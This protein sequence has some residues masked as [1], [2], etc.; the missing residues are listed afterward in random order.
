MTLAVRH[1]DLSLVC[2]GTPSLA[3]GNIDLRF[4]RKVCQEIGSALRDHDVLARFGG[5]EFIVVMQGE[6]VDVAERLRRA[7]HPPVQIGE[8]ELFITASIGY[9]TNHEPGMSPN[10]LMR[11]ADA[12]MYRAKARG[13]DCHEPYEVGGFES[14]VQAL[15]TSGER[16]KRSPASMMIGTTT[17]TAVSLITSPS[18]IHNIV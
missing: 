5:D 1:T 12:A 4:I 3:N 6:P 8:H 7:I 13:R 16:P 15:R 17:T 9:A 18:L 14:G 10:D 11:D 2:V